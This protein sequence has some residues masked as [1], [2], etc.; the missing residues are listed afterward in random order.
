MQIHLTAEFK[1]TGI[2][3]HR[4]DLGLSHP[5][6]RLKDNLAALDRLPEPAK[7]PVLLQMLKEINGANSVIES[8]GCE[9]W[10]SKRKELDDQGEE[11]QVFSN[12]SYIALIF[13][14]PRVGDQAM[15]WLSVFL[16][17]SEQLELKGE[18]NP[19]N[20]EA[21]FALKPFVMPNQSRCG[22]QAE[23]WVYGK[24]STSETAR[25]SWE[26]WT[27]HYTRLVIQIAEIVHTR[28]LT[29][30]SDLK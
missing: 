8:V 10:D 23:L 20:V 3:Y 27:R 17:L 15:D 21:K 16:M 2:P 24:W 5:Y 25:T 30:L 7:E 29:T 4:E 6:V 28:K 1:A 26:G 14:D 22:W 18:M 19:N 11:V 12:G 13:T 9:A